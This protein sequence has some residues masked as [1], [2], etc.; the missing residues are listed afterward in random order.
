MAE[1]LRAADFALAFT[2][3]RSEAVVVRSAA[4]AM[5]TTAPDVPA[6]D[7]DPDGVPLGLLIGPGEDLGGGDRVA[8]DPLMLPVELVSGEAPGARDATVLHRYH[9]GTSEQ[10]RA[11]YS[12]DALA[13]I[14][15]LLDQPGHHREIGVIAGLRRNE[16]AAGGA[17]FV[18][19]RGAVWQLPELLA[20]SA[21]PGAAV[22]ADAGRPVIRAGAEG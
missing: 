2:F 7:H 3:A 1:P 8:L 5:I 13:T 14:A 4:G 9:D 16:G 11:W 17:G 10:R 6:F 20:I 19:Y 15:A 22:L 18:R 21:V 12:R